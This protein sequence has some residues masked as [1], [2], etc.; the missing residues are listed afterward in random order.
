M[1]KPNREKDTYI[2]IETTRHKT[3]KKKTLK[4]QSLYTGRTVS[5]NCKQ[6]TSTKV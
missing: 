4:I 5:V 6:D 3:Q 2:H 1:Y